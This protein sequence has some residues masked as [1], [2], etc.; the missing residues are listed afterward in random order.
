MSSSSRHSNMIK[1]ARGSPSSCFS[2]GKNLTR[3]K[4]SIGPPQDL[5]LYMPEH[6]CRFSSSCFYTTQSHLQH[7]EG[8]LLTSLTS[9][10][11]AR[12]ARQTRAA[13]EGANGLIFNCVPCLRW[14]WVEQG[15]TR[16]G[17]NEQHNQGRFM[18]Q[19]RV[20]QVVSKKVSVFIEVLCSRNIVA[21]SDSVQRS[22]V[23]VSLVALERLNRLRWTVG[24][25]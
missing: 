20:Y 25:T 14:P 2:S 19:F 10:P 23:V 1:L 15:C 6:R 22:L 11:N 16:L 18:I 13:R 8:L 3:M 21:A 17:Q 12:L 4:G 5:R 24:A 7:I 9:F